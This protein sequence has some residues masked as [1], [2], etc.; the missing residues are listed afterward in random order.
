MRYQFRNVFCSS[1]GS[2]SLCFRFLFF[3]GGYSVS[4]LFCRRLRSCTPTA[5]WIKISCSPPILDLY[6]HRRKITQMVRV[7]TETTVINDALIIAA[8]LL[9]L[10]KR[11]SSFSL[12]KIAGKLLVL[13]SWILFTISLTALIFSYSG[14]SKISWEL[15][16][17]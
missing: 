17:Y 6:L 4:T 8:Q 5:K 2:I 13:D 16:K 7:T 12:F 11:D 3:L 9:K 1:G 15:N 10:Q 14:L